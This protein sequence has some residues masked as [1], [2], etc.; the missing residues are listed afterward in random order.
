MNH[1]TR[2]RSI[3][4]LAAAVG[5]FLFGCTPEEESA[6]GEALMSAANMAILSFIQF[7]LDFGRQWLAAFLF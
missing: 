7:V 1:R 6:V 4:L 2:H 3:V 5:L